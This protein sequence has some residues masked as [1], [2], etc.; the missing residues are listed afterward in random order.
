MV[1]V[2]AVEDLFRTLFESSPDAIFIEDPQG[3]VLD[4][5][6]A[7]AILHRTDRTQLVGKHVRELVPPEWRDRIITAVD[8]YPFEFEGV[9]LTADGH[10]IPVGIRTSRIEYNGKPAVLLN[11]RDIADRKRL[12]ERL[13][14]SNDELELRVQNRTAALARANEILREEIAERNRA[15]D[16]RR[17]LEEQIQGAQR[18]EAVGRLAGGVAHDFNNLLTVIIGRCEVMVDRLSGNHPMLPDVMLIHDAAH[19]AAGVT[20]QLLAFGRKQI[21]QPRILDLNAVISNMK[22]IMLSLISENIH[23]RVTLDPATLRVEADRGQLEQVIMN[24]VVNAIDAMSKGGELEISTNNQFLDARNTEFGALPKPGNYT[25]LS[26]RD[27]GEGMTTETLSHIFE[28]FFTTKGESKGTGLGL[29][30]VYGIVKQSGG[31][32]SAVSAK[33]QGSTFKVYLPGLEQNAEP[34]LAQQKDAPRGMET[35]LLTEDAHVVRKLTRELLENRGYRVIEAASGEEAVQI[36]E[37]Y[38]GKIDL[39]LS[40]V[41]MAR[42]NG[43]EL[44]EKAVRIRPGIKVVLMSGYADEITRNQIAKTGFKFIAKPFTSNALG[45]KIREA[46]E[47]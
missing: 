29:S 4:C 35:V 44:A 7:A 40:D 21:L 11:V 33:G 25:V 16:G 1:R 15:E 9:S 13:R 28:P 12:E 34:L 43:H 27:T 5:N 22:A 19:K 20:R 47:S 39:V 3:Y 37:S 24:L 30:T 2:G 8:E 23:L 32:I 17:Q 18:M 6:P 38:S 26:V 41:I 10:S 45:L 14:A 42:M 46:L 31:Y 36:C